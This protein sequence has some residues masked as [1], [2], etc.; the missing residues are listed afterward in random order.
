MFLNKR[1][2]ERVQS[3]LL[4]IYPR[5][6]QFVEAY[7]GNF[8]ERGLFVETDTPLAEG[9]R[10]EFFTSYGDP[11]NGRGQRH[12]L[13]GVLRGLVVRQERRGGSLSGMGIALESPL[14]SF[15]RDLLLFQN[16]FNRR[17]LGF[18]QRGLGSSAMML[19]RLR[20]AV[21]M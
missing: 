12:P 10:A 18:P 8:S 9:C 20:R 21:G 5:G 3:R 14:A 19:H 15:W 1:K 13:K 2:N 17:F 4:V 7:A 6:K 11:R 16:R